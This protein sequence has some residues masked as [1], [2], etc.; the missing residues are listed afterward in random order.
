M[1]LSAAL[2]LGLA[3]GAFLQDFGAQRS[4]SF[5]A[6]PGWDGHNNRAQKPEPRTLRQD[7]GYGPAERKV[8]GLVTPAAEPAYYGKRLPAR[9]LGDALGAS[10]TLAVAEGA[11][12]TLVG[13][14]NAETL[15]EWRTPN[16]IAFRI[17][18]R[19]D[20]FH[21]HLEYATARWRA[22]ADFFGKAD[23]AS[24]K[25]EP[26]LFPAGKGPHAWTLAYDPGGNG[27]AGT[28]TGTFDGEP[29]VLHL[30][31][32]H[33]DD[34]ATFTRFGILTVMKSADSPGTLWLDDVAVEGAPDSFDRD[35]G[36]EGVANRRSYATDEVRPRFDFGYSPTRHAGGR[37]A[38]ELGGRIFRGDE[39]DPE[40]LAYYGDRLERLTMEKPLK[41][42]GKVCLRR[43]VTDSTSLVGFFHSKD[44]LRVSRAQAS[45][46]PENFLGVAIEGPSR[47]GFLFYP[48]YGVDREGQ[49]RYADAAAR[50]PRILPDGRSHDWTLEYTPAGGGRIT[51]TLDGHSVSL[52]VRRE[53]R[54]VG[55]R[56]DRFGIVTTHIDGNA[57]N[58]YLDDLSY[59][60][61]Q[62]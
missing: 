61:R 1:R 2:A 14:F 16:T 26:R 48:A 57:Q 3:W 34:G 21:V 58:V 50:P 23:A 56:F 8:G 28:V 32:G 45:G 15:K 9:S 43:G 53:D 47:E 60:W 42:S 6:D 25:K 62:P 40:R 55:A 29:L 41:A 10:G 36:W 54:D 35:P 49:A 19:G 22:G 46:F 13:F 20:G 33:K 5:D 12:N 38:G 39:R 59:T 11:G 24:G 44:S 4:Q 7:F 30:D 18:G 17:N 27:G 52:E 51:V 37:G 31:P